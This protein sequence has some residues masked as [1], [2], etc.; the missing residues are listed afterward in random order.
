MELTKNTKINGKYLMP[1]IP[2]KNLYAA[3]MFARQLIRNGNPAAPS[4]VRAANS[5][6][7]HKSDVAHYVGIAASNVKK[8]RRQKARSY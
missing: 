6:G 5:Y 2:D 8:R 1:F 7:V 4:I 3:V